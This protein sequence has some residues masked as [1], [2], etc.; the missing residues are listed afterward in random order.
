MTSQRKIAI[1]LT[2]TMGLATVDCGPGRPA[3]AADPRERAKAIE[4]QSERAL[5]LLRR[6]AAKT[7]PDWMVTATAKTGRWDFSVVYT[8]DKSLLLPVLNT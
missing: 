4:M 2:L 7:R 3:V 8:K 5:D 6:D 1:L